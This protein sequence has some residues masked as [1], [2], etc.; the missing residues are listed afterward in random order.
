MDHLEAE[1]VG[2][3]QALG[4]AGEHRLGADVDGDAADS[5]QAQLAS[6]RGRSLEDQHVEP[7]GGEV[8]GGGQAGD[9]GTDDGHVD[10]LA[11]PP[12]PA[13]T[14]GHNGNRPAPCPVPPRM[15]TMLRGHVRL[16]RVLAGLALLATTTAGVAACSSGSEGADASGG[17][18]TE[19]LSDG[20]EPQQEGG[21]GANTY[22]AE[23]SATQDTTARSGVKRTSPTAPAPAVEDKVISHGTVEVE[24][25]DVGAA[26]ADVQKVTDAVGGQVSESTAETGDDGEPLRARLVLRVP[27]GEFDT[28]MDRLE[29]IGDLVSSEQSS[30]TVTEEYADLTARM[31]AQEA[32]LRRVELLFGRAQSIRDIVS[33]ESQLTSRQ[34]ELDALKGRLRVLDDQ[35]TLST[36]AVH[37][38]RTPEGPARKDDT[39]Q[40]GFLAGL[41]AG[42][43]ALAAAAVAVATV[44][45]A[46]LPFAVLVLLVGLPLWLV[47]RRRRRP[48]PAA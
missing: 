44:A 12:H 10:M 24:S 1:V 33:I 20:A 34:A 36:I 4:P 5:A 40:A 18:T 22:S 47:L 32:S 28:A 11:H 8:A 48:A 6:D 27:A 25:D 41:D 38:S 16:G 2:Q 45:G 14:V 46:L 39:D 3:R 43:T 23:S 37:V 17:S 30:D 9:P 42:W 19:S 7:R 35:T 29:G 26:R 31:R 13:S 21:S 15:T